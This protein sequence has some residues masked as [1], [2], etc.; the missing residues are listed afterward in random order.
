AGFL[1]EQDARHNPGYTWRGPQD[2]SAEVVIKIKDRDR[3]QLAEV[4][5]PGTPVVVV[6]PRNGGNEAVQSVTGTLLRGS[7]VQ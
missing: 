1:R 4:Y 7:T 6:F 3:F 5:K 2:R